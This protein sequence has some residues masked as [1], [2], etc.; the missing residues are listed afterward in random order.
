M[1]KEMFDSN[2]RPGDCGSGPKLLDYLYGD[3]REEEKAGFELHLEDCQNC[4]E[5][6]GAFSS[7]RLSIGELRLQN[8]PESEACNTS[9]LDR[10][11]EWIADGFGVRVLAGAAAVLLLAVLGLYLIFT[12]SSGTGTPSVVREDDGRLEDIKP[13]EEILNAE[14]EP[15]PASIA[16]DE[17]PAVSDSQI[18][19][20]DDV[21][22]VNVRKRTSPSR[23]N[24]A[25]Q[26]SRQMA[27]ATEPPRLSEAASE[28]FEDDSLRLT[29]LFTD[30]SE[31]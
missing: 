4:A 24:S 28:E 7:L 31:D 6:L 27:E 19:A 17:S 5:E 14:K 9:L 16:N 26:P 11:R 30:V 25:A 23:R 12:F 21:R 10:F 18:A 22:A 13:V 1:V 20:S 3:M 15:D 29:D 2:R 8:K